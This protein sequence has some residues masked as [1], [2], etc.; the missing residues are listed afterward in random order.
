LAASTTPWH[1]A[2]AVSVDVLPSPQVSS[3]TVSP[4]L[5]VSP[6]LI[7]QDTLTAAS[8]LSANH[9]ATKRTSR[10]RESNV[11]GG[12]FDYSAGSTM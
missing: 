6:R 7:F 3:P 10:F 9:G 12:I 5:T 1:P 8:D 4:G 2:G 11:N